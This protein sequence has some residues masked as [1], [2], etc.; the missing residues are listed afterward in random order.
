M[1]GNNDDYFR[2]RATAERELAATA[3]DSIVAAVH[4]ELASRYE[5][6]LRDSGRPDIRLVE[7]GNARTDG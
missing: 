3:N 2:A 1:S 7:H 6:L 5:A 4:L